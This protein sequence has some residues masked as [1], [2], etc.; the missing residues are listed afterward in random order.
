VKVASLLYHD[1]VGRDHR[2][3]SG[4]RGGGPDRYKLEPAAFERHLDLLEERIGRPP[5]HVAELEGM[6]RAT[7]WLLTF[8]DGGA[9]AV[10]IGSTLAE[11]GWPGLF[12]VT[13]DY[14]GTEGF[15]S[16]DDVRRLESLGHA[17]GSHSCSHPARMAR[18]SWAELKDEWGR[19]ASVLSEIVEHDVA[20][21]SVPGGDYDKTVARAAAAVGIRQL[22]TSEP[23]IT[24]QNVDGCAV[25]G[26]FSIVRNV[27]AERAVAL[28]A[29]RPWPRLRQ[30]ASWQAKKAAKSVGGERYLKLRAALLERRR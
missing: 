11:R 22:F 8:D 30:F 14:I 26:R 27:P 28:A 2:S 10:E 4:F 6:D 23:V 24:V 13:V 9:S 29:A 17:I 21:A 15:V 25:F 12:F 7:P 3:T 19:S 5:S 16:A 1:V 18:C 20:L